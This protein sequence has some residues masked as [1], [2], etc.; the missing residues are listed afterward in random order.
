MPL[1]F[2]DRTYGRF[3]TKVIIRDLLKFAIIRGVD[4]GAAG[5]ATAAPIIRIVV[6]IQK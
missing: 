2:I 6:V 1:R 3:T 4:N 5:A